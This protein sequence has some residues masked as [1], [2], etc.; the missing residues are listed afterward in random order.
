MI[1]N[2]QDELYQL[3][4]KQVKGAK[5]HGNIRWELR[6]KNASKPFF[7]SSK[8]EQNTQNQ[9]ISGLYT[10]DCKSKYFSKNITITLA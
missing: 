2:L 10:D 7:K 3:G 6:A 4:N 5:L 1:K 9:T 8:L